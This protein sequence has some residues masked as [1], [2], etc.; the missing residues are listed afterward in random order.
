MM[1]IE[2][3]IY[4]VK[5]ELSLCLIILTACSSLDYKARA[6]IESEGVTVLRSTIYEVTPW[7][8]TDILPGGI[9][10]PFTGMPMKAWH[11]ADSVAVILEDFVIPRLNEPVTVPIELIELNERNIEPLEI[12]GDLYDFYFTL[13]PAKRSIGKMTVIQTSK[14]DGGPEPDGLFL[15][16]T[17]LHLLAIL[18]PR[19]TGR[20]EVSEVSIRIASP[21]PIQFSFDPYPDTVLIEGK[22]GEQS[23]NWHTNRGP[24]QRNF[25]IF[26]GLL[27]VPLG[28]LPLFD[29]NNAPAARGGSV[30]ALAESHAERDDHGMPVNKTNVQFLDATNG[31]PRYYDNSLVSDEYQGDSELSLL[32]NSATGNIRLLVPDSV[33]ITAVNLESASGIFINVP[34]DNIVGFL[35]RFTTVNIFKMSIGQ[36]IIGQMDFGNIAQTDLSEEYVLKDVSARV[37]YLD[38]SPQTRIRLIYDNQ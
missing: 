13:N 11:G 2:H 27:Q 18:I 20:I 5:L 12:S 22:V 14:D 3:S 38:G 19:E 31:I 28:G 8:V 24:N 10:A 30:M 32:Y 34:N 6:Q 37:L 26:E 36:P 29:K 25:F 15:R 35:D 17:D 9:N 21:V 33:T 7:A 16:E 1:C 23:A 4:T